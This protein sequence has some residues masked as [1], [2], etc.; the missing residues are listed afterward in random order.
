[1]SYERDS[2]S[3]LKG[4]GTV[5]A[6]AGARPRSDLRRRQRQALA[7]RARDRAMSGV[8]YGPRGGLYGG[9]GLGAINTS[10]AN[11]KARIPVSPVT[12]DGG[13]QGVQGAG[14]NA[15]PTLPGGQIQG[16]GGLVI[17]SSSPIRAQT[18][19]AQSL[20][21]GQVAAPSWGGVVGPGR[22]GGLLPGSGTTTDPVTGVT[23][24]NPVSTSTTDP[25][26]ST[27]VTSSG[28][29]GGGVSTTSDGSV[30]PLDTTDTS[31]PDA[32]ITAGM[33]TNMKIALGVGAAAALYFLFVRKKDSA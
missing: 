20:M 26:S 18:V 12:V 8:T 22:P 19:G 13:G 5:A 4:V 32:G 7:L 15:N 31:V 11:S 28:G 2:D 24:T 27:S 21:V 9:M 33:S 6:T 14:G 17:N 29:S 25:S 3:H 10:F 1:M 16:G 30:P 23:T